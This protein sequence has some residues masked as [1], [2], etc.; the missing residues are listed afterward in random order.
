[1]RARVA[2]A[3]LLVGL[4]AGSGPLA[5]QTTAPEER[6]QDYTW[7]IGVSVGVVLPDGDGEFT[8]AGTVRRRI[9]GGRSQPPDTQ[10]TRPPAWTWE[11]R[12]GESHGGAQAYLEGELG[13]WKRSATGG[14]D[15]DVLAGVNLVGV[16][17]T[18]R[19]DLS[20]GVGFGVHFTDFQAGTPSAT[21]DTRFG[22]NL[23]F[24]VELHASNRIGIFGV[25]RIDLLEGD[26][27]RQQSKI[28]G[29]VRLKL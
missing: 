19:I 15:R 27:H 21:G 26:R 4:F 18:R 7:G 28:L 16:V 20:L 29:G 6:R 9:G 22:G 17:P 8:L 24:G 25:G 23:Q 13:Y 2:G 3:G 5:A 12:E 11:R 1:M 10:G 14:D